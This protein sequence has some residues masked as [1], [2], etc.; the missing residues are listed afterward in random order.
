MTRPV[1]PAKTISSRVTSLMNSIR[2][3]RTDLHTDPEA[4]STLRIARYN[5][6]LMDHE[7]QV[8]WTGDWDAGGAFDFGPRHNLR[9]FCEYTN[10][11]NREAEIAEY[12]IELMSEDGLVVGRFGSSFGDSV[13]VVPGASRVLAGQWQL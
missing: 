3:M 13:I 5:L 8:V 11:T 9:I 4:S 6:V 10:H 1:E 2:R 7:G 12:E